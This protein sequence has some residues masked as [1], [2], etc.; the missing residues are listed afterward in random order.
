MQWSGKE[1]KAL[2]RMIVPVFVATLP[3]PLASQRIPFTD[4][5]LYV[6]NLVH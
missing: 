4:A 5:Q 6:K 2:S 1:T 3:N